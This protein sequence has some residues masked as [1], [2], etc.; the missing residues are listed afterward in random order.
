[1]VPI[2][3]AAARHFWQ[4]LP[5]FVVIAMCP[6]ESG[7]SPPG[8]PLRPIGSSQI[9]RSATEN[10]DAVAKGANAYDDDRPQSSLYLLTEFND[11]PPTPASEAANE[12]DFS[13]RLKILEQQL[14][15][16][17]YETERFKQ[18]LAEL[19]KKKDDKPDPKSFKT[20]WKNEL[21]FESSDKNFV[22]HIGGRTQM[23]TVWLRG[24]STAFGPANGFGSQNAVD[25]RRARL[26]MDGTIY[27]TID[28][29]MEYDFVNSV[30][31]NVGL[32]PAS[33]TNTI[34]VAVPTDL[35]WTFR[36]VPMAGNI[37][38]GLQKEPIGLEHMASS[39]YLDFMERSFL[40][41]AYTGPFNNGFTP[42][43]SAYD[44]FGDE[45]RGLWHMGIFKNT[46]TSP[47]GIFSYAGSGTGGYC[48]DGRLTYLLWH[49]D[50][51]RQ[52]L[53]VGGS[54]SHRDPLNDSIRIRSRASLR[55]GPGALNPNM[56][57][58]G[59]FLGSS[60][61]LVGAE[62]SLLMG[63]LQIQAEYIASNVSNARNA[64][65]VINYGS[66]FTSGYYV[67]GSYFLTGEHRD[68]EKKRGAFGRV[69]P[70]YNS[71]IFPTD[72]SEPRCGAW[73]ALVRYDDLNLNDSGLNGGQVRDYTVGLNWFLNPNMKIQAN[74]VLTDRRDLNPAFAGGGAAG[75]GWINGFG[76]RLAH[77]F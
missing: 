75:A 6:W 39:R 23:D 1:M 70:K 73:Q 74:Y 71:R 29:A 66:Y 3:R 56:A 9:A 24:N 12:L 63:S 16:Q 49:E 7:A 61:D 31:D 36:E 59:S 37:K 27:K 15:D 47:T 28:Y 58:S 65:G 21:T 25:F 67:M 18:Q 77:D 42:G 48:L 55:N 33:A 14:S 19:G 53:Q 64:T 51:G 41:D 40:Q 11:L 30:N 4:L 45:Q 17:Q 76:M 57:D 52:M 72:C 32:Q 54:Y 2:T 50:E 69:V 35:W 22:A 26:R 13:S 8:K 20:F 34:G 10:V 68:Y 5:C 43:V 44:N 62:A 60:Q 38:V 46:D